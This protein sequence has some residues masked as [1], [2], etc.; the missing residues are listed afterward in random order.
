MKPKITPLQA[1]KYLKENKRRH[2]LEGDKSNE[3]LDIIETALKALEIIKNK[4]VNVRA[5]C[6]SVYSPIDNLLVYNNQ[7]WN[8]KEMESKELTQEEYDL[9]KEVLK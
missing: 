6:K 3:C 4:K 8:E 9:L 5:L 7:C 2:W 1:L